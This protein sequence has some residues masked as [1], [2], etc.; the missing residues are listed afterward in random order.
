MTGVCLQFAGRARWVVE[1]DW[2]DLSVR[3]KNLVLKTKVSIQR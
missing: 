1:G 3:K 2:L